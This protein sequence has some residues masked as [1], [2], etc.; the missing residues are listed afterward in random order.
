MARP[1]T[2]LWR[3]LDAGAAFVASPA[4]PARRRAPVST[5]KPPPG[6]PGAPGLLPCPCC[7]GAAKF[8]EGEHG[9][10]DVKVRCTACDLESGLVE[11]HGRRE[12]NRAGAAVEWNRR[13]LPP[14]H[15]E[16]VRRAVEVLELDAKA[17]EEATVRGDGT[18]ANAR[19]RAACK[20]AR[21]LASRLRALLPPR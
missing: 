10:A 19:D 1:G 8:A 4:S 18:F 13:T 12:L 16:V 9:F 7:G 21:S 15:A 3:Q 5:G 14:A 6:T 20:A 17:M 2:V 11:T